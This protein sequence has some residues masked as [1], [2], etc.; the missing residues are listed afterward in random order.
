MAIELACGVDEYKI[1]N[2]T[3]ESDPVEYG[4][5]CI[6]ESKGYV[7]IALMEETDDGDRVSMLGD[8]TL[9][10]KGKLVDCEYTEYD[11]HDS[12]DSGDGDDDDTDDGEDDSDDDGD[13]DGEDDGQGADSGD[14]SDD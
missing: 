2:G 5:P 12:D 14:G 10:F 3:D 11:E 13:G 6:L 8:D 1:V 4:D 9:I 7:Y